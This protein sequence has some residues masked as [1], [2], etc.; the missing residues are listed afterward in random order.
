MPVMMVDLGLRCDRRQ[1]AKENEAEQ[2]L[3]HGPYDT[4]SRV[5]GANAT[6]VLLKPQI[7]RLPFGSAQGFGG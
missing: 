1:A 3:F 5:P 7:P 2:E 4:F 6:V